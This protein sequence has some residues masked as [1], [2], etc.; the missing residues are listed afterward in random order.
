[1]DEKILIMVM[2]SIIKLVITLIKRIR[3]T[4][5]LIMVMD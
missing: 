2:L 1:M 4:M 5:I 3:T